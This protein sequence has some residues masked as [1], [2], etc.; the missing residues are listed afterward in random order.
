[1]TLRVVAIATKQRLWMFLFALLLSYN[2]YRD[3]TLTCDCPS[4]QSGGQGLSA[5]DVQDTLYTETDAS[6]ADST[7][8]IQCASAAQKL[9]SFGRS[10]TTVHLNVGMWKNPISCDPLSCYVIGFEPNLE[11]YSSHSYVHGFRVKTGIPLA[12]YI[13]FNHIQVSRQELRCCVGG[14]IRLPRIVRHKL[15]QRVL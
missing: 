6:L 10:V 2:I 4:F 3:A 1:M 15:A 8:A 9:L 14:C 13:C 5:I 12:C 11:H 7:A